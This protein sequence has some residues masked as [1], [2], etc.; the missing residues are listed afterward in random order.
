MMYGKGDSADSRLEEGREGMR[1][2]E[3]PKRMG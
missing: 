3:W 2:E 1:M